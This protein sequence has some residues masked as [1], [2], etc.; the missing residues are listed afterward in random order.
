[1]KMFS[2]KTVLWLS[3]A[4]FSQ[5][6]FSQNQITG[7]LRDAAG[8]PLP[9]ANVLL[10]A[11]AD[12][13]LVRGGLTDAAGNFTF[14]N[15]G[16]GS[17]VVSFSMIGFERMFSKALIFNEKPARVELGTVVLTEN[18][19]L[20]GEVAIVARRP[21]LEQKIDRTVVNVANSI[22]NAGGTALQV[23]QRSPGVQ[24]NALQKNISLAGKQGV[25]VMVN[26]KISRL[27]ADAVVDMLA[28]M[29]ADNIDRIELI[30]T[31]PANF[32]AE[33]NAGIINIV[34]KQSADTGLNGGYS[35]KIGYG[36]G[37][38][39]GFGGYF[40]QR[41]N[42]VNLFGS[43]DL[44]H[45][46]N[47]QV[48]TN[49]RRVK[50]GSDVLETSS[51]S[52][53]PHTPTTTQNAR[54]GAD[55]QISKR[56]IVGVLGTFFDRNWYM[57]AENAVKYSKNGKVDSLLRMPN[58]ETN[59]NRSFAGNVNL[60]HQFS[61]NQS[62][63]VDADFI[64]YDISNPSNYNLQNM[65]AAGNPTS[66]S[67]LRISK[68][69]PIQVAVAKADYAIGFGKNTRLET[70]VKLTSMRFENNV[71]VDKRAA[72]EA[73][74]P[75]SMY[76]SASKM[77]EKVA[78][79]FASFSTKLDENTDLKAGLRYEH[80]DTRLDSGAAVVIVDRNYGSWF[81]SV[82]VGRKISEAQNL[83]VSYSRRIARPSIR[84][85]APYL[86]FADPTTL[87]G[88]NP[89]LQPAFTDAFNVQYGFKTMRLGVSYSIENAPVSFVPM[90]DKTGGRQFNGYE[91]MDNLKTLGANFYLP[92]R[93]VSWW[94]SGNNFYVNSSELN[95]ELEGKALKASNLGYGFNSTNTFKLSR[96]MTL[97][98]SGNFDSPSYWGIAYWRATGS[99]NLGIE[100]NFGEKWGKLRLNA[101]DL[102]RTENSWFGTTDQPEIGLFVRSSYQMSERVFMLS[103][104]NTFGNRKLKSSRQRQTGAVEELRRI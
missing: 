71:Q 11:T 43:F 31:P 60:S 42:R 79:A 41:K 23:L 46:L 73:W 15:V 13:S 50:I 89:A 54:L 87:E 80:T 14:E 22:T 3:L 76:T 29:N 72:Q 39:Y 83:T 49:Y 91:N 40:N 62:L 44:D 37:R 86:I 67:E 63:N 97:E 92:F 32:E 48:F 20:L 69:T 85:L 78:G 103:W 34:L 98:V 99:L 77:D 28:G 27:P 55:F 2:Q 95:F 12:S 24:V 102:F 51:E 38:K 35:S 90:V 104:T 45:N 21:F 59:H 1:M 47:P 57:E 18:Q 84:R 96:S 70:G 33:G 101:N 81:P 10:L 9:A 4:L 65:D 68:K 26:G 16:S 74:Q 61:K 52:D 30:H 5:T 58:T 25:V 75:I 36:S 88:G 94:E 64:N 7:S 19:N 56:T 93:P 66:Q 82:F 8:Q 53:R 100:Q 6:I 17:F